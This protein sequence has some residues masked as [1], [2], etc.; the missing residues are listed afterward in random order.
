MP[1][2]PPPPPPPAGGAAP[3]YGAQPGYSQPYGIHPPTPGTSGFA[4][5]SLIFGIFGGPLFAV[6]FGH[7]ALYK[8]KQTGQSGRGAALAGLVLGYGW[9]LVMLVAV[10]VASSTGPGYSY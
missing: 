3:Q 4:V 5:V 2:R 9:F 6:I 10:I 1:G 7:V 8:I